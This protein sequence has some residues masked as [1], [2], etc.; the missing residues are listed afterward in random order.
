ML[1][2]QHITPHHL[3][4]KDLESKPNQTSRKRLKKNKLMIE[5]MSNWML[6]VKQI[7]L[8]N[9]ISKLQKLLLLSKPRLKQNGLLIMLL[10][11]LKFKPKLKPR[12]KPT[13]L[14][15]MV[16]MI[17][18]GIN[19]E[20]HQPKKLLLQEAKQISLSNVISKSQKLLLLSKPRLKQNGMLI[21]QLKLQML[22][23]KHRPRNGLT[24][25]KDKVFNMTTGI[26]LRVK[27]DLNIQVIFI[28][29]FKKIYK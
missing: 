14:E 11:P 17:T 8:S 16:Y 19:Q 29:L 2:Q 26:Y 15:E 21:I 28:I 5:L 3:Y 6:Q 4:Q 18:S 25:N 10:K 27:S 9:V 23:K 12:N 22:L 7:S 20:D 24:G 1:I 13:S